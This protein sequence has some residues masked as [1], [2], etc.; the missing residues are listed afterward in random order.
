MVKYKTINKYFYIYLRQTKD[1]FNGK[2]VYKL[3]CTTNLYNRDHQYKTSEVNKKKFIK[4]IRFT[5]ININ[6]IIKECKNIELKYKKQY[7]YC[8][9]IGNT[10]GTEF[11]K[12]GI[13]TSI[14]FYTKENSEF[15][16]YNPVIITDENEI[17]QEIFNNRI[18]PD[19]EENRDFNKMFETKINYINEFKQI[20]PK[21]AFVNVNKRIKEIYEHKYVEENNDKNSENIN[22][23]INGQ[24]ADDES[25]EKPIIN[26][27]INN[28]LNIDKELEN[29]KELKKVSNQSLNK[30]FNKNNNFKNKQK[31][32]N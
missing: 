23:N 14:S 27:K 11:Y 5:P 17:N 16:K 10:G 22:I 31:D 25:D 15:E 19:S 3:G 20:N 26:L 21:T 4:I 13:N 2:E 7:K 30:N 1:K 18:N 6:N 9:I 32:C 28:K 12:T 8:N 24:Y 29:K